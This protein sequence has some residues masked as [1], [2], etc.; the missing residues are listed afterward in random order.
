MGI[1]VRS[2][3]STASGP[4][5]ENQDFDPVKSTACPYP[6][7]FEFGNLKGEMA[8]L[9]VCDQNNGTITCPE[10]RRFENRIHE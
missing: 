3:A 4:L 7:H 9:F 2:S 10:S 6:Y 1:Q 8:T 5:C